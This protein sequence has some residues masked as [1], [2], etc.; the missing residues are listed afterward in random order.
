M[1]DSQ[2]RRDQLLAELDA[3]RGRVVELEA[4]ALDDRQTAQRLT[5]DARV[6]D[7]AL[8]RSEATERALLESAPEALSK[9][10]DPFYTTK[11]TGTGLGLSVSYAIVQAHQGTVAVESRPGMGITFILTFPAAAPANP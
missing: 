6:A 11:R 2:K 7:A 4:A 5:K 1:Q 10:F 8:Q 9:I 3:L